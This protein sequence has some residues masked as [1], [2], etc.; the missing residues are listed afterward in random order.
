[1]T[2]KSGKPMNDLLLIPM[3]DVTTGKFCALHRVFGRPGADGKFGKGW[4]SPAGGVFPIGVDVPHGVVFAGEGIATVLSWYQYWD[5]E[6]GN[7]ASC[8]AIAAMDAGN[9]IKNAAAIRARYRGR[10]VFI[11]Q[12]DDEA[13]EKA[14]AACMSAGFTG[15][16]NPRDYIR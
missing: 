2:S 15:V 16:V 6:S 14:A 4:C 12:D 9:L 8:T 1:M 10:E 13:G 3:M 5:E 7:G 11:L